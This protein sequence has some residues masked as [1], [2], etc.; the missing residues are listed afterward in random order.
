MRKH[1]DVH[2]VPD[3]GDWLVT[4][5]TLTV[6]RHRTQRRAVAAGVRLARRNRLDLVTHARDGQ[7]RSK[8][9]YGD[10]GSARDTEH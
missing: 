2:V 5:A 10:E 6:S 3:S 9:S 1:L 7:I 4:H 8:D